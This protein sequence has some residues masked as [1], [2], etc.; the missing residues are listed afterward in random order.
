MLIARCA[1]SASQIVPLPRADALQEVARVARRSN[2]AACRWGP[3]AGAPGPADRN[4]TCRDGPRSFPS[5][6]RSRPRPAATARPAGSSRATSR[7]WRSGRRGWPSSR[8]ISDRPG[9]V[10]ADAPLG[11]VVVVL[12]P[13]DVA[14]AEA[15]GVGVAVVGDPGQP[16][17][18]G[19]PVQLRRGC[20]AAAVVGGPAG[21]VRRRSGS[22]RRVRAGRCG[23]RAPARRPGGIGRRTRSAAGC[24]PGTRGRSAARPRPWPGL[25]RS[26][27]RGLFAVHVLAGPGAEDGLEGV[28]V[29]RGGDQHGVDVVAEEHLA[30]VAVG[31]AAAVAR[32]CRAWPHSALRR[33]AWPAL[34][35]SCARRRRPAPA[36]RRGR[37]SRRAGRSRRRRRGARRPARRCR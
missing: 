20:A 13:V 22:N 1:V 18:V 34:A 21:A 2:T 9:V 27:A 6:P 37:G 29:V 28:G 11:D 3:A 12:A 33:A 36:R 10:G 14:P 4:R 19:L 25:R 26:S 23:R 15:M 31:V 32:P 30:E 24:R 7:R 8:R 35:R 16:V 17:Q 5:C